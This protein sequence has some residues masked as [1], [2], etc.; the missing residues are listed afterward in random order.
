[1]NAT[2]RK[3]LYLVRH[4]KSSWDAPG[5][6]DFHRYLNA[7]G[8]Q[9]GEQMAKKWAKLAGRVDGLFTSPATRAYQTALFFREA[10][11]LDWK[12]FHLVPRLYE[13]KPGDW[14]R[15]L[16]EI[17]PQVSRICLFGHN[18][19]ISEFI[20]WVTGEDI[21]CKTACIAHVQIKSAWNQIESL[22]GALL[23]YLS[24]EI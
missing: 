14:H 11:Q 6:H 10:I 5:L 18:P 4:A 1:M 13:A 17:D 7:R 23:D 3:D 9:Q 22:S 19:G 20:H 2:I 16:A 8:L 15:T 24:P 21:E 12:D